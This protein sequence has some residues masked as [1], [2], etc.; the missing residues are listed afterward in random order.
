MSARPSLEGATSPS[1]E[2]ILD[3]VMSR[4]WNAHPQTP[5]LSQLSLYGITP[6]EKLLCDSTD[7]NAMTEGL[8]TPEVRAKIVREGVLKKRIVTRTVVWA[9]RHVTLTTD[10]LLIAN[11]QG[12]EIRDSISLLDITECVLYAQHEQCLQ[13]GQRSTEKC[14]CCC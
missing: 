5:S 3:G 2:V 4:R 8:M 13:L 1:R 11:L 14:W 6:K 7:V 9:E 12:G 10:D